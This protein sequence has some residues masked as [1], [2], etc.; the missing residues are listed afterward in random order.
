MRRR[1]KQLRYNELHHI[2]PKQITKEIKRNALGI[3]SGEDDKQKS[4]QTYKPYI[5]EEHVAFAADPIV[6]TMSR[7][8]A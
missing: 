2:T 8:Q 1:E 5:E 6:L 3:V 4:S 7:Q